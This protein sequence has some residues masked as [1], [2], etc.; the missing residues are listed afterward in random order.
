MSKHPINLL[1][2]FL[3]EIAAVIVVGMWGWHM[4]TNTWE[5]YLLAIGLPVIAATIWGVFR[6]PNDPNPAPVEVPGIVRLAYEL[7]LFFFATWRC[8]I[9]DI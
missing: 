8:M 9:W 5:Q 6:I 3:M 2:R 1:V 4:G 7:F